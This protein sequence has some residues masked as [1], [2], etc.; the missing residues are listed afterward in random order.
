MDKVIFLIVY[1]IC[2]CYTPTYY[3]VD[4]DWS[5]ESS[6]K[7]NLQIA[8]SEQEVNKI[9]TEEMPYKVYS[10]DWETKELK[11]MN[12]NSITNR[13]IT[14]EKIET[15]DSLDATSISLD[16]MTYIITE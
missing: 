8:S 4:C 15:L 14:K 9:I 13:Y 5:P 12:I 6:T 3:C 10:Y 1:L 16:D 7:F 11:E 2:S